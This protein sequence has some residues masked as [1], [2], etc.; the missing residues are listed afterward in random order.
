MRRVFLFLSV[1]VLLALACQSLTPTPAPS[2]TPT[3]SPSATLTATKTPSPTATVAKTATVEFT[4]TVTP[5]MLPA[6]RWESTIKKDQVQRY[7]ADNT[8]TIV[9][10]RAKKTVG[11]IHH[12]FRI[13]IGS[14]DEATTLKVVSYQVEDQYELTKLATEF[15][16]MATIKFSARPN[17]T[18]GEW[19]SE[20]PENWEY[21]KV[22]NMLLKRNDYRQSSVANARNQLLTWSIGQ[23][24]CRRYEADPGNLPEGVDWRRPHAYQFE[25]LEDKLDINILCGNREDGVLS[26]WAE[27]FSLLNGDTSDEAMHLLMSDALTWMMSRSV[28]DKSKTVQD[29]YLGGYTSFA[30]LVIEHNSVGEWT[31]TS[32]D[33]FEK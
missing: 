14:P 23:V 15:C 13:D 10:D 29:F 24:T 8:A 17:F 6:L 12:G 5:T 25:V 18:F 20:L 11:V 21:A 9:C 26:V 31:S 3:I 1:L 2:A 33:Q 30:R 22:P 28:D 7:G 27:K 19:L 16:P 4:S 32:L